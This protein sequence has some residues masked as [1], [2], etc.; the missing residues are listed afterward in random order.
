MCQ[1]SVRNV[2]PEFFLKLKLPKI[3][4]RNVSAVKIFFQKDTTLLGFS[5]VTHWR[6]FDCQLKSLI[7]RSIPLRSNGQPD[8]SPGSLEFGLRSKTA[9]GNRA[10]GI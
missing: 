9:V 1:Q 7:P 5:S 2:C 8:Q 4:A 3:F 6:L 10:W